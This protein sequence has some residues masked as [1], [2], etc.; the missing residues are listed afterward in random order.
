MRSGTMGDE[1]PPWCTRDHSADRWGRPFYHASATC[2]VPIS[3][4]GCP[5]V[6][7]WVDVETAQ[8]IPDDPVEAPWTPTVE[9]EVHAGQRYR[10]IVLTPDEARQLAAVLALAA[11]MPGA[12]ARQTV[13]DQPGPNRHERGG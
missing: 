3:R 13:V 11:D 8:H 2:S 12:A 7:E 10:M 5:D 6:P 1:C 9:I 4:P